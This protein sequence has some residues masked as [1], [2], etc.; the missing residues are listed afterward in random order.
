[1]YRCICPHTAQERL[2][3]MEVSSQDVHELLAP[4]E[5]FLRDGL[6]WKHQS[7][8]LAI[9]LSAG[10]FRY[11]RLPYSF[12]ESVVVTDRFHIKPL[13]SLLTGDGR[14]YI[15]ALS[16]NKVRLLQC[17]RHSVS[18]VDLG[19]VPASL[20]EALRYDDSE[21]QLQFHTTGPTGKGKGAAIFHGH[22]VGIDD[23]KV[24]IL[25]Y[26]RQIDQ[27]LSGLLKGEQI[28]LVLVG[29]DYLHPIYREANTYPYLVSDGVVGNPDK[30][31]TDELHERAW[32][33]IEPQFKKQMQD[34]AARY[35]QLLA[36]AQASSDLRK[37]IPAAYHGRTDVLFVAVGIQSWGKFDPETNRIE[38]H[39]EAEPGDEDLLDFAAIHT[40][41]NGGTVYAVM[42][43][44]V[45]DDS[46]VAAVLRY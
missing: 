30:L 26:F 38:I 23:A 12:D 25:R 15:L 24:N 27:G 3:E 10:F 13:L 40:F 44:Q 19:D 41:L 18:E 36:S 43:E 29:V 11:Y 4:M 7:D 46:S 14:F 35:K 45:P 2:T 39:K 28:P 1:V 34:A 6:F 8:G 9:F 16:Q 5:K 33:V 22:G 21:R 32:A 37:V 20:A 42:P 17:T 31:R